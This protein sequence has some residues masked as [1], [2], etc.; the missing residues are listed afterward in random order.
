MNSVGSGGVHPKS[1]VMGWDAVERVETGSSRELQRR[2]PR[3]VAS[4]VGWDKGPVAPAFSLV[5]EEKMRD[6][7]ICLSGHAKKRLQSTGRNMSEEEIQM[8]ARGIGIAKSKGCKDSLVL[9]QGM[10]LIVDVEKNTVV[11]AIHQSRLKENI[12]TNIDSAIIVK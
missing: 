1:R 2:G 3:G 9:M 7:G 5:L 4:V 10:A 11:T 6:A 8:L 12:F